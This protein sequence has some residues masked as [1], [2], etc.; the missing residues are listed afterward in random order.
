M[1]MNQGYGGCALRIV[2]GI[3]ILGLLLA[4]SA[5]AATLT[6]CP[7]GCVYSRIQAAV[8]ASSNG[9]TILVQSGP[10]YENVNVNKQLTLSGI[11]MPV[12]DARGSGSAITLAANGITLEGF[13][14]TGSSSNT[15][16]GIR[17]SSISNTLSGNNASNNFY[18]IYLD[19]SSN[20]NT[21]IGNNAYYN[22][23]SGISLSAS[24]NNT[25]IE[26][27]ASYNNGSGI[28]LSSSSNNKL[29]GNNASNNSAGIYLWSSSNNNMLSGNDASNNTYGIFLYPSS[30][31]N[32]LSGNNAKSNGIVGIYLVL[33]SNN[34]LIGNNASNNDIGIFQFADSN[35]NTLS[36]NNAS[37]NREG[38]YLASSSNNTL[39]GNDANSNAQDGINLANSSNNTLIGNN[40]SKSNSGTGIHLDLSGNNILIGNNASNNLLYGIY[41]ND[42]SNNTIYNNYFSNTNNFGVSG[43]NTWNTTLTSGTNII[44]GPNIGGNYWANPNGTGFSQTCS[45]AN[46]DGICDSSYILDSNNIDYL[47]FASLN[48]TPIIIT[49][50]DN[51][52]TITLQGNESFLLKLGEDYDWNV[53]VDNQTV[54]SRVPNV[55]VIRG[56]QGIYKAHNGYL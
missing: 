21:L 34:T 35:N 5:T 32:M 20:N 24:N 56:A 6:V 44:H 50:A 16:A 28:L 19:S 41:L 52:K 23:V 36:G 47:P 45:D 8:D 30:N 46:G 49:L 43:S 14:A 37:N 1:I 31:N 2:I 15:E 38:I 26:N 18:G 12:V 42:S 53:T 13:T 3:T 22:N 17:V 33:S 10:Y 11:G 25:L 54:L 48:L 9:D 55:L 29:S 4:G 39:S 27:N 51:G 40:A 7:G